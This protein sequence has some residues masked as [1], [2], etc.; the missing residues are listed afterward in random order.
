MFYI[1]NKRFK[2]IHIETG[3]IGTCFFNKEMKTPIV[4]EPNLDLPTETLQ[5][6]HQTSLFP[7]L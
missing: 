6:P 1:F 3:T 7:F 5:F 2:I 4:S